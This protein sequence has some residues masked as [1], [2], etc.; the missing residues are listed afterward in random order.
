MFAFLWYPINTST[1]LFTFQPLKVFCLTLPCHCFILKI[2][3][4][5]IEQEFQLRGL[6]SSSV[7]GSSGRKELT[8]IPAQGFPVLLQ[9]N[10]ETFLAIYSVCKVRCP[11]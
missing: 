3:V 1:A 11:R 5:M 7:K 2:P 8:S 10:G 4:A 9:P 6:S